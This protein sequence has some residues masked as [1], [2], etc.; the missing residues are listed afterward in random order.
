MLKGVKISEIE[1][2]QE[3]AIIENIRKQS[4]LN[5]EDIKNI[6]K[7]DRIGRNKQKMLGGAKENE[8]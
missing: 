4:L 3:E 2:Q 1:I 5:K 6:Y 8:N 7:L